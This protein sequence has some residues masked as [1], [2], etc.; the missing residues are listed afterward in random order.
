MLSSNTLVEEA[1]RYPHKSLKWA[2]LISG[3]SLTLMTTKGCRYVYSLIFYLI[4]VQPG[5][6]TPSSSVRLKTR[7]GR[8]RAPARFGPCRRH[9]MTRLEIMLQCQVDVV[10]ASCTRHFGL[11]LD[12][13]SSRKS[14]FM[15]RITTALYTHLSHKSIHCIYSLQRK[16]KVREADLLFDLKSFTICS[17]DL[18]VAGNSFIAALIFLDQ[19]LLFSVHHPKHSIHPLHLKCLSLPP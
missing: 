18:L 16:P 9:V 12:K 14:E 13:T 10:R 15:V 17:P 8:Q 4:R 11:V 19:P 5:S 6:T 1:K 2:R 3:K 7:S